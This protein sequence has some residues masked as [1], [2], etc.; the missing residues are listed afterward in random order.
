MFKAHVRM[1]AYLRA[2]SNTQAMQDRSE[3]QIL[4]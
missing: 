4:F 1:V 3:W 2:I